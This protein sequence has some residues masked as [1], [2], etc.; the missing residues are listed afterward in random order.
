[1]T[2]LLYDIF[3]Y[4]VILQGLNNYKKMQFFTYVFENCKKTGTINIYDA[5][6]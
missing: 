4:C 1:M 3:K 2:I 5:L 6:P